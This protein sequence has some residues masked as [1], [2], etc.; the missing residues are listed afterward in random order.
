[1]FG[2]EARLRTERGRSCK[3]AFDGNAMA[4]GLTLTICEQNRR[5]EGGGAGLVARVANAKAE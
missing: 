1:M 2:R 3:A 5:R 4:Q